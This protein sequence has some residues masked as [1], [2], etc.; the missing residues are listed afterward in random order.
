LREV[1]KP[2]VAA[3]K[4]V[5]D[6]KGASAASKTY[7]KLKIKQSAYEFD[8]N[9]F[10]ILGYE[11]LTKGKIAE[12]LAVFKINM[13]EFPESFNVFDSYAEAL[14][15][16]GQKDAA[17]V[18]YKKSLEINPANTNATEMLAKMGVVE[19]V[20][21]VIIDE[22]ILATYVGVYELAPNFTLT[23]SQ[24]GSQLF[25]Q[26]TG[27]AKFEMF[28]KSNTEFYLK[29][30]AAQVTFS[31]NGDKVESLTLFQNGQEI[32]GKRIE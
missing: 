5:I 19:T 3:I 21:E 9:A 32:L 25:G 14:M 11:Y 10:N 8:E 28:A 17:I 4:N 31:T 12:A 23:I 24:S 29:A 27:Q 18:Y 7:H 1:K 30:V 20:K 15:N 2:A 13:D 26:A 22:N 16:D 6:T